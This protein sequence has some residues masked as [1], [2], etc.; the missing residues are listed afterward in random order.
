M[1][2]KKIKVYLIL[3]DYQNRVEIKLERGH[4]VQLLK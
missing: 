2:N 1:S 4:Q 3:F